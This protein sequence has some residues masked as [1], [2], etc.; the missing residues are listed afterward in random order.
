VNRSRKSAWR[1]DDSVRERDDDTADRLV[2]RK[3][4][5]IGEERFGA[6]ASSRGEKD[7]EAKQ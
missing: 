2:Q 7:P 5:Q 6:E 4:Y 1:G 3:T